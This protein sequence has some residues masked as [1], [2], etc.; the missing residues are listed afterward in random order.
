[1]REGPKY[2]A[3]TITKGGALG[4]KGVAT[5]ILVDRPRTAKP[6]DDKLNEETK[7]ELQPQADGCAGGDLEQ[8]EDLITGDDEGEIDEDFDFY[9]TQAKGRTLEDLLGDAVKE[10]GA[11]DCADFS[12]VASLR[13]SAQSQADN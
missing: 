10:Q 8:E 13:R 11:T 6:E 1:M 7:S 4:S 2:M 9:E 5:T 12:W 3:D